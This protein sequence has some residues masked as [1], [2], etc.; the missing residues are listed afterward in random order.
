GHSAGL[1]R[2]GVAAERA[3]SFSAPPEALRRALE[4][5]TLDDKY[6]LERGRV[7]MSG[8]QALGRLP[9]LQRARDAAAGLD[10]AGRVPGYRA[11]P[12]GGLDQALWKARD[13][14][15]RRRLVCQPGLSEG[16]AATRVGGTQQL[17]LSGKARH[18]GGFAMW[19]GKGPGV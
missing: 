5:V 11:S 17:N 10:T 1:G 19:Y 8:T 9:M 3:S 4:E 6:T 12:V 13:N 14:R 7:F 16:L 18:A 15:E 2:P